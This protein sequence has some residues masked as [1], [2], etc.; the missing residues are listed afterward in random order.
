MSHTN[1]I[2]AD[3]ITLAPF[4]LL[5]C[6]LSWA[7]YQIRRSGKTPETLYFSASW[8]ISGSRPARRTEDQRQQ[9]GAAVEDQRQR[10][11]SAVTVP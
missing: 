3:Q 5:L 1:K 11:R 6:F 10:T 4:L 2:D 9:I 7:A 8:R